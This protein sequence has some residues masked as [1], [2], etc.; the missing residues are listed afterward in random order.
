MPMMIM[1]GANLQPPQYGWVGQHQ[2][3]VQQP[4]QPQPPPPETP[5]SAKPL[6]PGV[7]NDSRPPPPPGGPDLSAPPPP[8]PSEPE[9]KKTQTSCTCSP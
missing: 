8:P 6:F 9:D 2:Q 1:P 3:L 5:S 4:A 7:W